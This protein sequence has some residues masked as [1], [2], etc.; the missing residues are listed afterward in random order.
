MVFTTQKGNYI[1]HNYVERKFKDFIKGT[2]FEGITLHSLRHANASFMLAVGV[3]LKVVSTILGHASIT[4]QRTSTPKF[5][6]AR[7]RT[8]RGKLRRR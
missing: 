2:D 5:W 6:T 7:R 8:R 3:D 1:D 4:R